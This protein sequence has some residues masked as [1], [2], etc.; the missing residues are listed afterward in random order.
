MQRRYCQASCSATHSSREP[1]HARTG[2]TARQQQ[3]WMQR[4][5]RDWQA[6][7]SLWRRVVSGESCL[8]SALG[9][10]PAG[11][12]RPPAGVPAAQALGGRQPGRLRKQDRVT[13]LVELAFFGP[14]WNG[15]AKQPR[16]CAE[17]LPTVE[18]AL[19]EALR[20][21]VGFVLVGGSQQSARRAAMPVPVHGAGRTDRGVSAACQCFSFHAWRDDIDA[22]TIAEAVAASPEVQPGTLSILACS[23]QARTFHAQFSAR[24][25]RYVYV[26]PVA[27]EDEV[28]VGLVDASLRRLVCGVPLSFDAF[29]RDT[30]G[31]GEVCGAASS[32]MDCHVGSPAAP[33]CVPTAAPTLVVEVQ[34]RT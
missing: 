18:G 4:D 16:R 24:F 31:A 15:W 12:V 28:D 19:G 3:A 30:Q 9:L 25:R 32:C 10:A 20:S 1:V 14:A 13:Y 29:A 22:A 7:A 33:P 2:W 34:A 17:Q 26:F 8:P 6:V 23:A 5:D 11:V 21:V 27:R